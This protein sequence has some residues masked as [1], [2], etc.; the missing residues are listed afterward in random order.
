MILKNYTLRDVNKYLE[1]AGFEKIFKLKMPLR[2][3]FEYIY[4]NRSF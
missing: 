1:N 4:A 2:R 3:T